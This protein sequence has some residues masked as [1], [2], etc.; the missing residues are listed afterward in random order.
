MTVVRL[1]THY[2]P[3]TTA[4][5]FFAANT[6]DTNNRHICDYAIPDKA[7][8]C[9]IIME[10]PFAFRGKANLGL[11]V[12]NWVWAAVRSVRMFVPETILLC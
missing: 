3:V 9:S 4:E 8:N 5:W 10:R 6:I 7:I 1:P 2:V 11:H 12:T